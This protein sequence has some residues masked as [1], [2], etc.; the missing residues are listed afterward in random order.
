MVKEYLAT[1]FRHN[2]VLT[3]HQEPLHKYRLITNENMNN[4]RGKLYS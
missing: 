1:Y 4:V 3:F 2:E